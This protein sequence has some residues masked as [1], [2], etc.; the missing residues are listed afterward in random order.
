MK[1][2][3]SIMLVLSMVCSFFTT[4]AAAAGKP[5]ITDTIVSDGHL[6]VSG[7]KKPYTWEKRINKGKYTAIDYTVYD[8]AGSNMAEDGSWINVALTDGGL[9]ESTTVTYRVTDADGNQA[10]FTQNKYSSKLLNG[11]FENPSTNKGNYIQSA[12]STSNLYWNTT[13]DE[14]RVEIAYASSNNYFFGVSKAVDGDQFAE[15]NCEEEG[16]LYQDVLTVP[17]TTLNWSFY[18]RARLQTWGGGDTAVQYFNGIDTMAL[19]IVS[20]ETM[21]AI[22]TQQDIIDVVNNP[23]AYNAYVLKH[24]AGN[25]W[26]AVS[27]NYVVPAGQYLTR[28]FFVSVSA[29]SGDKTIGNLIDKVQFNAEVKP[30]PNTASIQIKK[31]ATSDEENLQYPNPTICIYDTDANGGKANLRWTVNPVANGDSVTVS[32]LEEGTYYIEETNADI[33]GY[34]LTTSYQ[35]NGSTGNVFK[36]TK[37]QLNSTINIVVNNHYTFINPKINVPVTKSWED[38]N[39]NDGMRPENITVK[40]L[41]GGVETAKTLILS[42]QNNWTGSFTDLDQYDSNKNEIVYTI[43]EVSVDEYSTIVTGN[44]KDGYVITNTHKPSTITVS[45]TKIWVDDNDRDGIRPDSITVK[46]LA[47]NEVYRQLT[48]T[49]ENNWSYVFDNLPKYIN[50]NEVV[51]KVVEESV[52]GYTTEIKGNDL[53]NTH[54]I[55]TISISGTKTWVGDDNTNYRPENVI[56]TLFADAVAVEKEPT[57]QKDSNV[58]TYTFSDLPKYSNGQLIN[59]TVAETDVK[60]YTKSQT[61]YDFINT[62]NLRNEGYGEFTVK[63]VDGVTGLPLGGVEFTLTD[64]QNQETV[65]TTTADG[66]VKF[67][68]LKAGEYT[69]KENTPNGYVDTGFTWTVEVSEDYTVKLDEKTEDNVIVRIWKWLIGVKPDASFYEFDAEN[70]ELVIKNYTL[71]SVT[72]TK[73]WDDK[74]DQDGIRPDTLEL[75]LYADGKKVENVQPQLTKTANTWTYVWGDLPEYDNGQKITYTVDETKVPGGYEK[76]VI[77]NLTIVNNHTPETIDIKGHKNWEDDDNAYGKRPDTITVYLLKN[78][79]VIQTI[80]VGEQQNWAWEFNELPK[81]EKG[82][83]IVYSIKEKLVENYATTYQEY[84]ITNTYIMEKTEIYVTKHWVDD[85]NASG[86]RPDEIT[87]YLVVNGKTTDTKIVL[88]AG[89]QWTGRFENLDKY[90]DSKEAEYTVEEEKVE[91]YETSIRGNQDEGFEITNT[92]VPKAIVPDTGDHSNINVWIAVMSASVVAIVSF[93]VYGKKKKIW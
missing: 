26:S 80:E 45:G 34:S 1:K 74:D 69:L 2:L 72:A 33:D 57:W 21:S 7:G 10:T 8:I 67:T 38:N 81:Y 49:A 3:L 12:V 70:N 66:Y 42:Q 29:A 5:D 36:I 43:E 91:N 25:E 18:H 27:G 24:S 86:K 60:Y 73:T 28:F 90:V 58:W 44:Q 35:V 17:G 14:K 68:D 48:V 11:S 77:D 93:V 84:N 64:K 46:L 39:D 32:N 87:V 53:I 63:K 89:N 30:L 65:Q 88:N 62:L 78:G 82:E 55:A 40:L 37:E 79:E 31:V 50:K 85:D 9:T 51:Y 92:Y 47:N 83:E 16:S 19:V 6:N 4:N 76:V 41:A 59:Y 20:A 13:A 56:V 52:D 75:V 54:E 22:K 61:G 23:T 71:T 15:L